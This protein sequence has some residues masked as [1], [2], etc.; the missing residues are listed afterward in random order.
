MYLMIAIDG[1]IFTPFTPSLATQVYPCLPNVYFLL[2]FTH[3]YLTLPHAC[4][5]ISTHVHLSLPLPCLP[6]FTPHLLFIHIYCISP[7]A[8]P[9][10][11]SLPHIMQHCIP[12]LF[13]LPH[14]YLIFS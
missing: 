13:F 5:P 6:C 4:V 14:V 2:T 8:Y 11:L 12:C 3:F 1:L 10:S 9:Y 7:H